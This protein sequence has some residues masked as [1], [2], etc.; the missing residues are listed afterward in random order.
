MKR[1]TQRAV[2]DE[3]RGEG[4]TFEDAK[5]ALS[6]QA[7]KTGGKI[8]Q[9]ITLREWDKESRLRQRTAG[10]QLV[11]RVAAGD[12]RDYAVPT[13]P[14]GVSTTEMVNGLGILAMGVIQEVLEDATAERF[15][16]DTRAKVALKVLEQ[17][18]AMQQFG[19]EQ[20]GRKK[21]LNTPA[22]AGRFG[23]VTDQ[24]AWLTFVECGERLDRF[25]ARMRVKSAALRHLPETQASL[26][27]DE[28]RSGGVP[29]MDEV[30][31]WEAAVEWARDQL[32]IH[33]QD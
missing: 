3:L 21:H 6:L 31:D 23:D 27:L 9:A 33:V 8:V 4:M 30:Y 5:T 7:A 22:L 18:G 17:S 10:N 28:W 25:T 1:E 12:T 26:I 11:Q 24:E 32:Q 16:P 2:W 20:G 13:L 19:G 29:L 14:G 15:E